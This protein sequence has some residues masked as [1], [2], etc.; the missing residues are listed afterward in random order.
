MVKVKKN[1]FSSPC[2][3]LYQSVFVFIYFVLKTKQKPDG[4][5]DRLYFSCGL[6]SCA[7]K[8]NA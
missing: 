5:C 3:T 2:L 8:A 6:K 7:L 1:P 4:H